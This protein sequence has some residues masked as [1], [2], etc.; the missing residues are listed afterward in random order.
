M[1]IRSE[2]GL[3][4]QNAFRAQ[5]TSRKLLSHLKRVNHFLLQQRDINHLMHF[6]HKVE[7]EAFQI[8]RFDLI[9]VL[10]Y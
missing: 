9:N 2:F 6:L 8:T 5:I 1:W 4:E 3:L 10:L 7:L